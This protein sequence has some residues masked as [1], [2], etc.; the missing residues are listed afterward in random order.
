MRIFYAVASSPNPGLRSHLWRNNLRASLVQ[1]GHE[2]IDFDYDLESTFQN[3]DPADPRQA[4]FIGQNRPRLSEALIDQAQRVH[5]PVGVDLLF[6]YFYNA[7]VEPGVIRQLGSLGIVTVNWF[8]NASY[9]FHLVREIAPEY[10]FCLVPE[11]I[12]ALGL[13]RKRC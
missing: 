1:L 4:A 3:L 2:I 13:P 10:D 12:Q 5:A 6:T 9:Q 7:C 11:K 8:C